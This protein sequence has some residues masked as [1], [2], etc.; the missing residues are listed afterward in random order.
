LLGSGKYGGREPHAD[1]SVLEWLRQA[2]ITICKADHHS[3]GKSLSRPPFAAAGEKGRK[4]YLMIPANGF[5]QEIL[6]T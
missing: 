4:N 6:T 2:A 5:L 3:E 1:I